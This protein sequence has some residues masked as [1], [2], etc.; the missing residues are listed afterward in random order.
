MTG[1]TR[2][3][4]AALALALVLAPG[5]GPAAAQ[6]PDAAPKRLTKPDN[7]LRIAVFNVNLA[8]RSAGKLIDDFRALP[9]GDNAARLNAIV[10]IIQRVAP[11][12]LVINELDYDPA[13]EAL[14]LFE[15]EL[16]VGR[17]GAPGLAFGHR[18]TAPVNTGV[19]SGF[20]LDGDGK[21]YNPADAFGWGVFEGQ[22]GMAVL[23]SAPLAV[24][25]ART[26]QKLTWA[27][28][29]WA[30]QPMKPDGAPYYAAEAWAAL[31]LSSK[32]HWDVAATLPDGRVVH[33]LVSHPTPPVFDGPEDR[34]GLRNAAEIL[35]W[36]DYV[37]GAEWMVDDKGGRGGLPAEASFV[38]LGDLNNDPKDGDGRH[39]A[40]DALLALP[41]VQDPGP[42]SRGGVEAAKA[43]GGENA[44]HLGDPALDTSDWKD[45]GRRAPGNLRVDYILPSADL[46]ILEAGVFWPP[47]AEP[48]SRL[49]AATEKGAPLGSDHRLVWIDIR[50]K[51]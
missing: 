13:G 45:S 39:D 50:L 36:R 4:A 48:L 47:T 35:F 9:G 40:I 42:T 44:K 18:F 21:D 34:N 12:I 31:R 25:K 41:R 20:D 15:T 3:L 28:A 27:S 10:E 24:D 14:A 23:S 46:E 1:W 17:S 19:R 29:P 30:R 32:S 33:L 51:D 26:F 16:A 43:Q 8:R 7:A 6:S 11:D 2:V 38:I 5:V 49:V 37:S 22:F